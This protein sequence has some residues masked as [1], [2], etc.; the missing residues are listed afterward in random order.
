[1]GQV[2]WVVI[3]RCVYQGQ[4]TYELGRRRLYRSYKHSVPL[5]WQTV[6][7]VSPLHF[8]LRRLQAVLVE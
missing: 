3:I 4:R 7:G 5:A 8:T 6:Q 2:K 1:M